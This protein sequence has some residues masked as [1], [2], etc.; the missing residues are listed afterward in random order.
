MPRRTV[1]PDSIA[2]RGLNAAWVHVAGEL[3]GDLAPG[4]A[5]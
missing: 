5:S 2:S 1:S 3:D 4:G